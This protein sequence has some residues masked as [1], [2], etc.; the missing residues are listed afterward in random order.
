MTTTDFEVLLQMA[1]S[2]IATTNIKF[3]DS[4]KPVTRLA[5]TLRFLASGD[6]YTSMTYTLKISKQLISEIVPEV[7]RYLNEA[8]SDYIKVRFL[9][10]YNTVS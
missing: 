10:L 2:S 1:G 7:C 4:V 3:R 5:V 9:S 6:S 8:L